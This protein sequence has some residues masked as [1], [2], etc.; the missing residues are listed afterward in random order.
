[1]RLQGNLSGMV[2]NLQPSDP[3]FKGAVERLSENKTR[4]FEI[5]EKNLYLLSTFGM[6][7]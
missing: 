7:M 4:A 2:F 6:Y 5:L 1:M 3:E